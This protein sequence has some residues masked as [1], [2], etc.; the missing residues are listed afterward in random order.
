MYLS[1]FISVFALVLSVAAGGLT[2]YFWRQQNRA[3]THQYLSMVWH[4]LMT[5]CHQFPGYLDISITECYE[6][7]MTG[8]EMS[9]YDAYCY[10][11]WV[12]VY[13]IVDRG[14]DRHNEFSLI[15]ALVAGY[16]LHWLERN[17]TFFPAPRFWKIVEEYAARPNLIFGYRNLPQKDDDIDWERIAGDYHAHILG[18]F[19]PEMTKV[20]ADGVRRN[21][22]LDELYRRLDD[23]AP[24]ACLIDFGCGPGNLLDCL[25]GRQIKRVTGV[26]TN[27]AALSIAARRAQRLKLPFRSERADM[28]TYSEPGSYDIAVIV[29]SLL[30]RRREDIPD[31]LRNV[32]RSLKPDGQL[33]AILPSYDTTEYLCGLWE[34]Y[35][36]NL[37]R[38]HPEH[39]RRIV[40]AFRKTKKMRP[41]ECSYADDGRASQFYHTPDTLADEFKRAG[42]KIEESQKI[43]YPWE[44]TARFDYGY[45]PGAKEE[46]WDWFIR[47]R[48]IDGIP[49][50]GQAVKQGGL[51]DVGSSN[52]GED[53]EHGLTFPLLGSHSNE[54]RYCVRRRLSGFWQSQGSRGTDLQED[55]TNG[56]PGW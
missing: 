39:A 54:H 21:F 11:A 23:L 42:I 24:S 13:E 49:G 50:T 15:I 2:V 51:A 26:D 31:I 46:I 56:T 53:G 7:H 20:G 52:Q 30:P 12:Y 10:K 14:Y 28:K 9:R 48:P 41:D 18:P 45:F 27:T 17:P 22:L 5:I 3:S 40:E 37:Y 34:E 19:A 4:E 47:A 16:H 55:R 32:A 33:L 25:K 6:E 44:L 38:E 8:E 29:N 36:R 1:D 43:R 35:Y